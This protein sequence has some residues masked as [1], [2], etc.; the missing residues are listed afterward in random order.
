MEL[1]Q[2]TREGLQKALRDVVA[3]ISILVTV[4]RLIDQLT[5]KGDE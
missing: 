4:L 1:G 5:S 2:I 3:I